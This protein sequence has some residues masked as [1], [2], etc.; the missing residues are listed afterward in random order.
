MKNTAYIILLAFLFAACKQEV[1]PSDIAKVN[2]YWEIE[3]VIFADGQHKDYSINETYDYFEIKGDQGFRKKVM[4]Q[5]NGHF[6]ANNISEHI[7]VVAKDGEIWFYYSTPYA[8]WKEELLSVTD[9]ELVLLNAEKK[10]YHYKKT[11]PINLTGDGK[12]I[13]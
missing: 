7:A 5:L 10:E 13:K 11:G 9:K 2:G 8:K 1:K 6:E 12:T 4:P 3:K